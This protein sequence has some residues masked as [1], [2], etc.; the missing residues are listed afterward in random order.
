K[1]TI[2]R[3]RVEAARLREQHPDRY[4]SWALSL[5]ARLLPTE[6]TNPRDLGRIDTFRFEEICIYQGAVEA[7]T[8]GD[9][10]RALGWAEA[11]EGPNGFWLQQEQPRRWAWMLVAEAARLGVAIS[12]ASRPLAGA[13]SLD[14]AVGRYTT[15]AAKVDQ[16]HRYFEQRFSALNGPQLP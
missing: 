11:R 3:C 2:K 1:E 15:V 16:A 8:N 10:A 6:Q 13:G 9:D 7:L 5:E 12:S 4:R 14:E